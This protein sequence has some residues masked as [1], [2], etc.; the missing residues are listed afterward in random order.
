M[1]ERRDVK[2]SSTA[3]RVAPRHL[4]SQA[5]ARFKRVSNVRKVLMTMMVLGA[6]TTSIG[7]GTFASL[8]ATVTNPDNAFQTGSLV[9]TAQKTSGNLCYSN[10]TTAS[11]GGTGTVTDTNANTACDVLFDGT[12]LSSTDEMKKGEEASQ[13]LQISNAGSIAGVLRGYASA[14]CTSSDD[15]TAV[16]TGDMDSAEIVS[17]YIGGATATFA[18]IT[19]ANN[20]TDKFNLTIDGTTYSNVDIV[21][22]SYTSAA[23]FAT[24]V[25]NAINTA[26]G[27]GKATATITD[28]RQL[29]LATV[30]TG[31]TSNITIATPTAGAGQSALTNMGF[32]TGTTDTGESNDACSGVQMKVQEYDQTYTTPSNCWYGSNMG[33]AGRAASVIGTSRTWGT[34]VVSA[35]T[36][37]FNLVIDGTT[38]TNVAIA[39]AT[40]ST[41]ATFAAAIQTAVN[42]AAGANKATVTVAGNAI[43]ITSNLSGAS[44]S[45]GVNT[46]SN[47]ESA[48]TGLGITNGTL[49]NGTGSCGYASAYNLADYSAAFTGATTATMLPLG[50]LPISGNRYFR[51]SLTMPDG[52]TNQLQGRIA[53]FTYSWS[54]LAS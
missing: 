9:F 41:P 40:Y 19:V 45:V 48:L 23:L 34:V 51:I 43:Q 17:S 29:V 30:A 33:G 52:T 44:S 31:T 42:T 25:Q 2:R 18:T 12:S 6:V 1:A 10:G 28:A 46:P 35:T 4:P 50:S 36:D 54:L 27:A 20:S 47:G 37:S 5:R 49:S 24:A 53:S 11:D 15:G 22:G 21:T 26:A 3:P 32:T 14:V 8:N 38:Y 39:A 16:Y 13:N 7:A